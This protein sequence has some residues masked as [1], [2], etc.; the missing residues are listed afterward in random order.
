[1]LKHIDN[2]SRERRMKSTGSRKLDTFCPSCMEVYVYKNGVTV[3][4]FNKR[5]R[6]DMDHLSLS[7]TEKIQIAGKFIISFYKNN[8]S[9]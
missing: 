8:F 4:F 3:I 9:S 5:Y 2:E 1:M 7:E 6:D